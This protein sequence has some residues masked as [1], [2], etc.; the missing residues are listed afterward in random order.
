MAAAGGAAGSV[1]LLTTPPGVFSDIVPFLVAAGSLALLLTP[2]LIGLRARRPRPAGSR[3]ALPGVGLLSV[4]GGYFG[5]GSGVM[6]LTLGLVLLDPHLP[7][8]NAIKNML[9]GAAGV[10]SAIVFVVAGP[11]DWPA[12]APLAAGFLI[13]STLGPVLA[14]RVPA[15]VVRWVVAALGFAL[16]VDLWLGGR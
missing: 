6:L 8:A 12:V 2:V 7:R 13:G 14:R 1:L 9:V 3:V 15:R 5:A 4:Y 10:A 16:A 11:V